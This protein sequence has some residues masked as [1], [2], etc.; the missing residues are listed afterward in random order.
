MTVQASEWH[1][2]DSGEAISK[3]E[4]CRACSLSTE[5]FEELIAYG[6]LK[7]IE[8]VKEQYL[9]SA[10]CLAPLRTATKLRRDFDLDLFTVALMLEYLG[11]IDELERQVKSLKARLPAHAHTHV[12]PHEG[13]EPWR[14]PHSKI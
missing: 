12:S 10:D 14:E 1:W 13:P 8:A 11:R 2:L 9:F 5:E 7:P 6:A 3:Q 4:L